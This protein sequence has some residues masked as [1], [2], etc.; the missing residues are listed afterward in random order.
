MTRLSAI[1][2]AGAFGALARYG[3]GG[4]IHRL[5]PDRFPAGTLVVNLLGCFLLGYLAT[6][7]MERW[8]VGPTLRAALLVGFL[9]AFTTFSTFGLDSL[10]LLRDGAMGR[11]VLNILLSV[12]LG[13]LL[14][15]AGV[16]AALRT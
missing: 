4:L 16:F 14:A 9:G 13:I 2:L 3:L 1:A 10:N 8:P 12:G 7:T 11:G 15:W 6:L 5:W